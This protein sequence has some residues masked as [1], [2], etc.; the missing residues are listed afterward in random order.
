MAR[1]IQHL[2]RQ[3]CTAECR[4][5]NQQ[6]STSLQ[7]LLFII[8]FSPFFRVVCAFCFSSVGRRHVTQDSTAVRESSLS[9]KIQALV[10]SCHSLHRSAQLHISKTFQYWDFNKSLP[11]PEWCGVVRHC[12]VLQFQSINVAWELKLPNCTSAFQVEISHWLYITTSN[13]TGRHS[14]REPI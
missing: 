10:Q 5:H 4:Y 3:G 12:P 1:M 8:K 14:P 6:K 11:V 7:L 2:I 13:K 9:E